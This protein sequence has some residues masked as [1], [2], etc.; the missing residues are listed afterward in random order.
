MAD[1]IQPAQSAALMALLPLM[2][3]REREELDMWRAALAEVRRPYMASYQEIAERLGVSIRTVIRKHDAL[4][5]EGVVGLVRLRARRA[6]VIPRETIEFWQSLVLQN[7]RKCKPA[8]R[9]LLRAYYSGQPIP[10][11]PDGPRDQPPI[12]WSYR[13]FMRHAPTQ[14]EATAARIGRRAAAKYRPLVLTTREKLW[15]GSH[16]LFDDLWHDH[17]CQVLDTRKVGRPLE[18]HALD[19]YSACKFAWGM[20]LRQE[21]E[22][23]SQAGLSESAMRFLLAYVLGEY[24]YSPRGTVL[25]VE[26]GTAAVRPE[27]E[28]L[29]GDLSGGKITVQRGGIERRAAFAGQ[30]EGRGVGNPRAKAALESLGNLIHNEMAMLPGQTG[31]DRE[32]RPEGAH[33]L[34]RYNDQLLAASAALPEELRRELQYPVIE[35]TRFQE[36]AAQI[37]DQINSRTD[38]NLEGWARNYVTDERTG[39][40]RR[41]SPREVWE[42]GREEL[43][44]LTPAAVALILG[45]DLAV[46]REVGVN[47]LIE[48]QDRTAAAGRMAYLAE[49]LRPGTRVRS[50]FNP[51]APD[52]LFCFDSAWRFLAAL[53]RWERVDKSD[54]EA[55]HRA[56]GRAAAVEARLLAPLAAR[57]AAITR[58]RMEMH[59]H[60]A[61]VLRRAVA[62]RE[63]V[64]IG[65]ISAEDA[66]EAKAAAEDFLETQTVDRVDQVDG[67]LD[68]L[69]E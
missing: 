38:H 12:G 10:G 62:A 52:Q 36:I 46:E 55:L 24:G 30:F 66:A 3:Q 45:Q 14:F 6:S 31:P 42:R 18:F 21:R 5:R 51:F 20:Q 49:G 22:D 1:S 28:R 17:F 7:Q 63:G 37:Y 64:G 4:V 54:A 16:Y 2:T 26:H 9:A 57:G 59:R 65:Q 11:V 47:H 60:N 39:L 68:Q 40:L 48:F 23:G 15:V 43:V 19:L 32:R 34:L 44:R 61:E 69:T 27:L 58:A 41:M 29:L 25:V 53:P 13:N 8:Y 33:G 67:F 56:C 35:F 50:V